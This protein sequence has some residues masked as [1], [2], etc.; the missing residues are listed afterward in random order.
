MTMPSVTVPSFPPPT[1]TTTLAGSGVPPSTPLPR[2]SSS[3]SSSSPH[4]PSIRHAG[5]AHIRGKIRRIWRPRY[6]ELWDTGLV[7]Y[8]EV[9]NHPSQEHSSGSNGTGEEKEVDPAP[10]HDHDPKVAWTIPKYTLAIYSARILDGTTLRDMHVGLPR[11]SF[12]FLFRGQRVWIDTNHHTT[13]FHNNN[14]SY[15]NNSTGAV[16]AAGNVVWQSPPPIIHHHQYHHA[17]SHLLSSCSGA[18]ASNHAL[19][20]GGFSP[21]YAYRTP[22]SNMIPSTPLTPGSAAATAAEPQQPRDYFCAVPT[23]EEAQ[24]WVIALQWAAEKTMERQAAAASSFVDQPMTWREDDDDDDEEQDDD[25]EDGMVNVD[26]PARPLPTSKGR[27]PVKTTAADPALVSQS[28]RTTSSSP[29]PSKLHSS[30]STPPQQQQQSPPSPPPSVG[31]VVSKVVQ[32][33]VV[34]LS[35]T[36]HSEIAYEIH[37]LYLQPALPT[38]TATAAGGKTESRR[39]EQWVILRVAADF[40]TLVRKL[41]AELNPT[42]T[43]CKSDTEDT[44]ATT[45][46]YQQQQQQQVLL[47]PIARLGRMANHPTH[48][49]LQSSLSIVDSILRSFVMDAAMVNTLAMKEFLGLSSSSSSTSTTTAEA[50]EERTESSGG[51]ATPISW[52][53]FRAPLPLP[54]RYVLQPHETLSLSLLSSKAVLRRFSLSTLSLPPNMTTDQYVRHWIQQKRHVRTSALDMYAVGGVGGLGCSTNSLSTT[55]VSVAAVLS[56]P[57]IT[58]FWSLWNPTVTMRLDLLIASYVGV[59]YL[60]RWWSSSSPSNTSTRGETNQSEGKPSLVSDSKKNKSRIISR[61]EASHDPSN[62]AVVVVAAAASAAVDDDTDDEFVSTGSMVEDDDDDDDDD[63]KGLGANEMIGSSA[64]DDEENH[65]DELKDDD[66]RLSSP[67]PKYPDNQGFS[68]WS[69]PEYSIFHVRGANYLQDRI[70]LPSEEGP[71]TCRGVDIWITD[72]PE[73]HIARHPA[74]LGGKLGE[75]DTF[76]VNFLLPF[77]NFVAYFGIPPLNKFP[78]KLR[79]VWTKFLKGDQEYRDARLKLLPVVVDGPWIV[80][81][82]VGSG[83]SPALLGKVVPLQ[84]FFRDA[85]RHHKGVY[86]VDVIITASSIAKGILSVVKGHTKSV[87]IAFALIIEAT[88]EEELPETVLCS[89]QIHSIHLEECPVLPPWS[90]DGDPTGLLREP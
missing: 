26:V 84:Y 18:G 5:P 47:R 56:V 69:Q 60:G 77:G 35:G 76:L 72:N 71:L 51:N 17:A 12:G 22:S 29:S 15:N 66:G 64:D 90:P 25:E 65:G 68:C 21:D 70:K 57:C 20:T 38:A 80:K 19:L 83:K 37:V 13:A 73:R 24:M 88:N 44:D 36:W 6:L 3:S 50:T 10:Y 41:C 16:D 45:V 58:R 31:T 62:P 42:T 55:A 8:S 33:R 2:S 40:E 63:D 61:H 82:A 86:E 11:G 75:E 87:S 67:L 78:K 48:A 4:T 14:N 7:R 32:Y 1:T 52:W 89:F 28:T 59:A 27:S 85:D 9:T 79:T 81:T 46:G 23:L 53:S 34:R 49:Q 54:W 43:F 39:A 74:V 30:A